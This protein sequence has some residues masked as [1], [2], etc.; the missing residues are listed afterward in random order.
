MCISN[1]PT[2][3]QQPTQPTANASDSTLLRAEEELE[4]LV[5]REL[6]SLQALEFLLGAS[7]LLDGKMPPFQIIQMMQLIVMRCW[8]NAIRK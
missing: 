8:A 5:A 4:L 1:R 3:L 6:F 7:L 2:I